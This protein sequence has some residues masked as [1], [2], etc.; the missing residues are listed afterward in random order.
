MHEYL[1]RI[2]LICV[3]LLFSTLL[4]ASEIQHIG[5]ADLK[6]LMQQGVTVIDVRTTS[7]WRETGVIKDSHLIMFFDEKGKYDL[8]AWLG[9]VSEVASKNEP[10]ILICHSGSRSK[11]LA[12]YLISVVGYEKVYNVK[13]GIHHWIKQ[14]NN[15]V[16]F[17]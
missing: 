8:H 9:Q 15:V 3:F 16:V 14:N 1:R 4:F 2:I 17:Q 7:E 5:N 13:R 6:S 12:K 10:V 11:Q